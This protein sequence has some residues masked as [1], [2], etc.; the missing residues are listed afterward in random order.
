MDSIQTNDDIEDEEFRLEYNEVNFK[1][2]QNKAQHYKKTK[3]LS[4]EELQV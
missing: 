3:M 1:D 4:N 2:L